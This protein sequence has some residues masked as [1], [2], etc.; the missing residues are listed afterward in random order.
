MK[1]V[2]KRFTS[3]YI[4]NLFR[5]YC[6][7]LL[8]REA[9]EEALDIGKTR[10]FALL[11]LYRQNPEAFSIVYQRSTPFRISHS[12]EKEIEKELRLEKSLIEDRTLPIS[13][14]N[15]SAIKDRLLKRGIKVSVPTIIDRAKHLGCYKG[16][17]KQKA[18]DRQVLT[19]AIG[20]LIQHDASHHRWSPYAKEKWVL[21][22][23][24]DD[25]SRKLLYAEF[26]EEETSWA[27]IRAAQ[28]IIGRYGLPLRYYVDSLRVFRF[29]QYRDSFW[30]R[31]V[32]GT[33]EADPQ[34]KQLMN[35]L[36]V[37]VI[38]ALS[39]Q[40]KGKIE[41]SFRWLQ[42]RI[43]RT[44]AIEKLSTI[45]ELRPVLREEVHRYNYLQ[46]HATTGEIPSFRFEKARKTGKTLFRPFVLPKPYSSTKDIF[47]LREKRGVN[48]YRRV[49]FYHHEIPAPH[50]P[51]GDEVNVHLVPDM[52]KG[53][54]EVRIWWKEKLVQTVIYLIKDFPRVHF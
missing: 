45:D 37:E 12:V 20:A 39:P 29:V 7:G 33:D 4:Q 31:L 40:A 36:G 44:A 15:Y 6:Q 26:F 27:H 16:R 1:Q 41:R 54:F 43:V 51:I 53:T 25:Y 47:C 18:H 24:L 13:G 38:Y 3:E 48:P 10:F 2:H 14:Y 30:R 49:S 42:D 50:V 9:I 34:W 28:A 19:T 17:P 5:G 52:S 32:L 23:S 22:S 21:I 8:N 46:V 11:K 35:S